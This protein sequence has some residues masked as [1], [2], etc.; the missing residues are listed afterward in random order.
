M[1]RAVDALGKAIAALAVGQEALKRAAEITGDS[2]QSVRLHREWLNDVLSLHGGVVYADAIRDPAR[3]FLGW[4]E[5]R[6]RDPYHL[7]H[8]ALSGARQKVGPDH[9][10][11]LFSVRWSQEVAWAR[12]MRGSEHDRTACLAGLWLAAAGREPLRIFGSVVD[13]YGPALE[14]ITYRDGGLHDL[15]ATMIENGSLQ[16]PPWTP[17]WQRSAEAL[18]GA[19]LAGDPARV[20][21]A[22]RQVRAKAA[23]DHLAAECDRRVTALRRSRPSL[24]PS[25]LMSLTRRGLSSDDVVAAEQAFLD[26]V[27]SGQITCERGSDG[28]GEFLAFAVRWADAVAAPD[29]AEALARRSAVAALSLAWARRLPEAWKVI[30]CADPDR[31]RSWCRAIME[32]ERTPPLDP[33]LDYGVWLVSA[34]TAA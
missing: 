29:G 19:T 6:V 7:S 9:A 32:G 1:S 16:S 14:D 24:S 33:M 31:L 15:T 10:L 34:P 17:L 22:A 27:G 13:C 26:Q 8:R 28:T 4:L 30:G 25:V 21:T 2:N 3:A 23:A 12:R 11:I 18:F 5:E 20:R